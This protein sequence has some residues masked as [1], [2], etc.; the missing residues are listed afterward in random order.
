MAAACLIGS[1]TAC[2][3]A[4][5]TASSTA[6]S[7]ALTPAASSGDIKDA[8]FLKALDKG[9][10]PYTNGKDMV[11]G[12]RAVCLFMSDE[13]GGTYLS[14]V[15]GVGEQHPDLTDEQ[16]GFVVGAAVA[17]FCPELKAKLPT[18]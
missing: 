17:I 10:V 4:A 12:A 3:H 9:N 13:N 5:E 6:V 16:Q 7:S 2:S 15:K 14:A 1:V 8:N 18:S 11:L